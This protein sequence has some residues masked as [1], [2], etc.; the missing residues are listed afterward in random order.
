[1]YLTTKTLRESK[2]REIRQAVKTADVFPHLKNE[3]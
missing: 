3:K 2:F 1:M